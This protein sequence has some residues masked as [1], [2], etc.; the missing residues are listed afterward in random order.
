[1][2]RIIFD[3]PGMFG[4]VCVVEGFSRRRLFIDDQLQGGMYVHSGKLQ[5]LGE[6]AY[7]YGWLI[8]GVHHPRSDAVMVG[9]GSSAGAIT[10]L[11][12]FP[13]MQLTVVEID[14]TIIKAVE[15]CFP[16]ADEY[17]DQ[18]RLQIVNADAQDF[19]ERNESFDICFYDAYNGGESVADLP[20]AAACESCDSVYINVIDTLSGPHLKRCCDTLEKTGHQVGE[21]YRCQDGRGRFKTMA[22]WVVSTDEP[23]WELLDSYEPLAESHI[24]GH[25]LEDARRMFHQV[26]RQALSA[27]EYA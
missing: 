15:S 26:R 9:L 16:F 4:R 1:M 10:L 8:G 23:Q 27:C 22:N 2:S 20:L 14:P 17:I 12:E 6:N 21:I 5:P 25:P 19:F 7:L 18:G 13:D 11:A 3:E 24:Q